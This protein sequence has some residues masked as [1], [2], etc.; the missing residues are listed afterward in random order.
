VSVYVSVSVFVSVSVSF[1]CF[2]LFPYNWYSL[3][4]LV[5]FKTKFP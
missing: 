1:F 2:C 5:V 4:V 3:R